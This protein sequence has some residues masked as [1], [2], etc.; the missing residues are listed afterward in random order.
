MKL[1][2]NAGNRSPKAWRNLADA[3]ASGW[4]RTSPTA[5]TFVFTSHDASATFECNRDGTGYAACVSGINY[6]GPLAAGALFGLLTSPETA[7]TTE[8]PL[9]FSEPP[10]PSP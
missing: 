2:E 1:D 7:S 9:F 10:T 5:A 8:P 3:K 4:P 6:P